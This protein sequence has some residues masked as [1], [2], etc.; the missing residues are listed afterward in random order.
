M[1]V[2]CRRGK[3]INLSLPDTNHYIKN[4]RNKCIGGSSPASFWFYTFDTWLFN[5]SVGVPKEVIQVEY[6]A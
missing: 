5:I 6:Y 3:A 4:L 2:D 1:C